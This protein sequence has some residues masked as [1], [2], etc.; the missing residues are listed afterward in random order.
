VKEDLDLRNEF[1]MEEMFDNDIRI[2]QYKEV[3]RVKDLRIE[4]NV[5]N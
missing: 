2:D 1:D 5:K 3:N 4:G